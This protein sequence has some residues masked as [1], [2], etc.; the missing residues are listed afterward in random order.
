MSSIKY[1]V[2]DGW[3]SG[4]S[5]RAADQWGNIPAEYDTVDVIDVGP[6]DNRPPE[7][8]KWTG[9]EVV[10][11]T[12]Q[13]V[14][15]LEQRGA[16]AEKARAIRETSALVDTDMGWESLL[17]TIMDEVNLVRVAQSLPSRSV[18]AVKAGYKSRVGAK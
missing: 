16:E 14:S 18:G 4:H 2:S 13:E 8:C 12:A 15:E 11:M 9:T 7:P 1:R 17:E 6:L 3:I 5:A 10:L